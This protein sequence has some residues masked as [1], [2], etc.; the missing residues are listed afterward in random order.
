MENRQTEI[1]NECSRP[2]YCKLKSNKSSE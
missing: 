1:I 2:I